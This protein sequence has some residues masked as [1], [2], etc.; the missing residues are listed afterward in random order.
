MQDRSTP[1]LRLFTIQ[2]ATTRSEGQH[3]EV[4]WHLHELPQTRALCKAVQVFA[5]LQDLSE[6]LLH[7]DNA[8]ASS[9]ATHTSPQPILTPQVSSHASS[10]ISRNPLMMTS[11]VLVQ[12]PD[13]STVK[14][15]ALL[16]SASSASFISERLVKGLSL[17]RLHQNTT[18]V[19]LV[20]LAILYS[21][22]Q[23]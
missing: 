14:A 8:S 13:G 5:S 12:A 18:L 15:R 16:D 7:I 20:F 6:A 2:T 23:M 9:N 22:L 19:L 1:A 10:D 21:R 11:V 3:C 4:E 17:P